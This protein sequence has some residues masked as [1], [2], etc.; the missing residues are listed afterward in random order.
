MTLSHCRIIRR[1]LRLELGLL[2]SAASLTAFGQANVLT[3][4]NDNSRTGANTNETILTPANVNQA[5][6][7]KVFT[8]NVDGQVYAQ[9]LYVSALNIAGGT[10]N[11]V[12]VCTEHNSVYAF[13]A[14]TG[15]APLWQVNLGPSST[16]Q[17][18][19]DLIPEIGI[20]G[21][22]VIDLSTFTLYV[23]AKT[24]VGTN[25]FHNLHALDLTTGAEKFGAPVNI[26]ATVSGVTF[27]TYLQAQRPG[28]L[29]LNGVVY[30]GYASHCDIGNYHGWLLGYRAGPSTITQVAAFCTTPTGSQGGIWGG[31]MGP[32]ADA[33]GYIY[34]ETGNGS[35]DGVSNFGDS[36]L[37]LSTVGGLSLAD[38]FTPW[39]QAC[40]D[41]GD[42]DLG[43]GGPIL[44]PPHYVVGLGKEGKMYLCDQNNM[45]HFNSTTDC[46]MSNLGTDSCL[47]SFVAMN[48]TNTIGTSPVYWNGPTKQ[49][50]FI[51]TGNNTA[52]S[53]Q[54]TGTSI[55]TT[56]LGQGSVASNDRSGGESLSANGT[57]N[58][59][60]WTTGSDSVLRAYDAVNFPTELWDS[61]Q[62]PGRDALGTYVKFAPPMIANGMVYVG[63]SNQLVVYGAANGITVSPGN[64]FDNIPMSSSQAGTFTA[65]FDAL[66]SISPI[67]AVV[68]LSKGAQT[69]YPGIACI[70]RFNTAGDIDAYN[71]TGYQAASVIPYAKNT[72]YHFRMLVNVPANTY[73]V[74]VTPAGGSE[75]TVGLNYKFRSA[76]TSLDTWTIDVNSSPGGTVTVSNRT[77]SGTQQVAAPTFNPPAGTYTSA[78]TVTITSTTSGASIA[79]T[80]DGSTPTE[81]GGTITHGTALAN[82]GAVTISVTTTLKAMAFKGGMTDSPVTTGVY[83]I[84]LPQVAAPTFNPPAGTYTSAQ[85]VTITSATSGAT[86]VYTTDG[87]APTES[88]GTVT[89]GT[90]LPIGGSVTISVTT[91]LKAMAFKSGMTDSP[92]TT[93]LYTIS[94]PQV[95]APTFT[96]P[97]GT[98]TSAQSVT[99]T[100]TTSGASIAYTTDG[101][102]PTES[103]GTI[104]HG[105]ALANGGAITIS[106]TTTLKALAFESGMTDSTV[107]SGSYTSGPPQVAAPTFNPTAGTYTS[108][109]TVTITSAT[110]GASIA[111]TTDGST[112]TESGDTITHG[113]ALANGGAVTISVTTTLKAMAFKTGIT[114]S[115]VTT[116]VYTISVVTRSLTG[117]SSNGW[118]ALALT[119]A[120][121]GTFT[122]TFDATPTVSPENAVVGLSKGVATA[123][124]S[125]S[126]IARFNTSGDIDAYNGTGYQ[127]ASVIPYAKNIAYHFRMVV[128]VPA[129][130]YSVYV[131]PAGG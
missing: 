72:T 8:E 101:S 119:S 52:K 42:V 94:Q 85:T 17:N 75:L 124:A 102:T 36:F 4:H 62:N 70:A 103:G 22:P 15:G 24:M 54:F 86:I 33:N 63:T 16:D 10:H 23:D 122:A 32:A 130:T 21:T 44:V 79:Y 123:Y 31:G 43:S 76:V 45:G 60:L 6:F 53:Y 92:L 78:Q 2:L 71:G 104:T 82:G 97:A 61:S 69:A 29:L 66:P 27:D 105:T 114:D 20:T 47:Q 83:T 91:T 128:N 9:P 65:A 55:N 56:P 39:N 13:D 58:G 120:Q 51:A 80:T 26:S 49:Y 74:Y 96:P 84:S 125:I 81:S 77:I 38:W 50:L 68:G 25:H 100:S 115:T 35:W 41:A 67:N 73:S 5:Q 116:G 117:T 64:G 30:I 127:A 129:H 28:L 113:T 90:V 19:S 112:P 111:Y 37:K 48:G 18:C 109:Q 89:H 99:I 118:H 108:A 40:L 11:V 46:T 7:G 87:T 110:S 88:G 107:T 57:A 131:T 126:C 121:T 98:Y 3:Q 95:A 34:V 106:V 93:G 12:Y 1:L 59:I 14:N